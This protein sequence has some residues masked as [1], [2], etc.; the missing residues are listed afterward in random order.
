MKP[1]WPRSA[2]ISKLLRT[3]PLLGLAALLSGCG[4]V[5]MNPSGDVAARQANLILYSTGLMLLIIVPVI[6][7]TLIFAWR[8]RASNRHAEYDPEWHHST[9]LEVLIWTA[10]LMIIIALG[11]ITWLFTH[12]LD[13]YRP[14]DRIDASTPVTE[15]TET[16]TVQVVAMD[17]KWMFIYPE[18][19]IATVNELAAPVDTPINFR[20]T[21][22][23]IMNAFYVPALSGMIYAMPGMQTQLHA[24]INEEGNYA[25]F[26]ANYSGPGFANMRFRFHGLSAQDFDAWV[27]QVREQGEPLTAERYLEVEAPSELEPV[28]YYSEV[29]NGLYHSIL[30]LCVEPG[31]MCADEMMHIDM[32]GGAGLEGLGNLDRLVYDSNRAH[33]GSAGHGPDGYASPRQ[34]GDAEAPG[35]TFPASSRP[36][37]DGEAAPST[38]A[39]SGQGAHEGDRPGEPGAGPAPDASEPAPSQ[40]NE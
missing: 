25:G 15:E 32:Q 7:F 38:P 36:P 13:P 37:R 9:Q 34:P 29:Q 14:L 3:V 1:D 39:E 30:N 2:L 4:M 8:Y 12:L 33:D 26:S 6:A 28:H 18:L 10:P 22:T 17:W 16:L 35:A 11:A 40:L 20:L 21:S 31:R 24:V 27:A 23:S 5:V 19:G